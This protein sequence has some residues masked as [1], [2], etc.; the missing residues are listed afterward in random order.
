VACTPRSLFLLLVYIASALAIIVKFVA[1][2]KFAI[3]VDF[4]ACRA[5]AIIVNFVAR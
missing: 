5:A 1:R 2:C 4:V 3:V